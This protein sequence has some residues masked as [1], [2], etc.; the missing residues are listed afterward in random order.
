MDHNTSMISD[1]SPLVRLWRVG[2]ALLCIV[3]VVVQNIAHFFSF[4]TIQS[5]IIGAVILLYGGLVIPA[6]TRVWDLIRG[7]A[8]IY[9]MLTGVIYNLLLVDISEELQTTIP[10]VNHVLHI[11]MPL[12]MVIDFLLI[13][14]VHRLQFR[15]TIV[16]SLYPLAYFAYSL[17]RGPIVDWYPYPFLD[18]RENG[19]PQV[20]VFSLIV[21]V[22]F[23]ATS[24][25]LAA[26][27]NWRLDRTEPAR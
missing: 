11:V 5:N 10:W 22:C 4:F 19:Y 13:P 27:N 2:F 17:I 15:Q 20:F 12:V 3:A 26:T 25:L 6:K 24:W 7:G 1:R 9:L 8:T 18:P 14:L 21:L 23:L 16:W